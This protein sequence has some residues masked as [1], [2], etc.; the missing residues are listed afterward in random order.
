MANGY[1]R[2]R[3][4]RPIA[5]QKMVYVNEPTMVWMRSGQRCSNQTLASLKTIIEK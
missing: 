5:T 1:A 4:S 3:K 2:M